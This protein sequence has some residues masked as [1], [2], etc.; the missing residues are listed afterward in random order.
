MFIAQSA[1]LY[2]LFPINRIVKLGFDYSSIVY[3][4]KADHIYCR[5]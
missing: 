5:R 4:E 1:N 3:N 2:E